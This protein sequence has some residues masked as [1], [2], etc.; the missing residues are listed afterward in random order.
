MSE[1]DA[2]HSAT[3]GQLLDMLLE[4][5]A[6][7]AVSDG[8]LYFR[9]R[10]LGPLPDALNEGV[11][12]NAPAI[13]QEVLRRRAQA[14]DRLAAAVHALPVSADEVAAQCGD[15]DLAEMLAYDDREVEAF[16]QAVA[17]HLGRLSAPASETPEPSEANDAA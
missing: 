13:A 2:I 12:A 14:R 15:H 5:R 1:P 6:E 3:P 10:G 7:V 16:A 17:E 9:A 4:R 8:R 11:K